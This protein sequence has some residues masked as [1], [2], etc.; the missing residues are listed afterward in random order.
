[1]A[2]EETA[3][4]DKPRLVIALFDS[5]EEADGAARRLTSWMRSN[6]AARLEAVGVLVKDEDGVVSTR[7]LGPREARRG[8]ALGLL[9]GA[10]AG[11]ASGGLTLLQGMLLG[12]A[13][14][15]ALGSLFHKTLSGDEL[16]QVGRRLEPGHAAVGALVPGRQAAAVAE[17]LEEY[18]GSAETPDSERAAEPAVDIADTLASPS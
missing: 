16:A 14:G 8:A 10:V 9:A 18:G 2:R 3:M 7:K 1:M 6:P 12:A 13:G 5:G 15:G 4:K 11:V 17:Q